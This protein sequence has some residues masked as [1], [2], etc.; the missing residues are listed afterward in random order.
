MMPL[1]VA[2]LISGMM[3]LVAT[4]PNLVIN[5]ELER[6]DVPGFHF[7]SFTPFGLTILVL[8]ILYMT[9]ARRW[10]PET[11]RET[12]AADRPSFS[13]WIDEYRLADREYRLGITDQ[14]PLVGKTLEN[15]DLRQSSVQVLSLSNVTADCRARYFGPPQKCSC[16][17][18]TYC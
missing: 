8:G 1:S 17:Q 4:A 18:A 13:T 10:L 7:F 3:T 2:A 16:R 9:F 11:G 12:K 6:H 14:S 15:L 5:S